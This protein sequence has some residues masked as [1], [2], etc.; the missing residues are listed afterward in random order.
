MK[1]NQTALVIL[2]ILTAWGLLEPG[3][4][5]YSKQQAETPAVNAEVK[6]GLKIGQRAPD[7]T[8]MTNQDVAVKLSDYRGRTVLLNFW[9]SWCPPCQ[10]EMPHL[11]DFYLEY[12]DQQVVV[13]AVNMTHLEKRAEDAQSYLEETGAEFPSLYDTEGAVTDLYRIKA[14][15]T[16][17]VLDQHGIIH[18]RYQ[19]AMDFSMMQKAVQQTREQKK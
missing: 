15:P 9:A 10:V 18:A 2:I 19:G 17:Y 14:Y 6:E 11:R 5:Q 1:R 16:T 13:L 3:L 12:K 7:F 8:L 4:Q